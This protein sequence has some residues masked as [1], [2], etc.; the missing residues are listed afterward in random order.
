VLLLV[1]LVQA[2][3]GLQIILRDQRGACGARGR[4]LSRAAP[5]AGRRRIG[6]ALEREEHAAIGALNALAI[7]AATPQPSRVWATDGDRCRRLP[8]YEPNVALNRSVGEMR[9]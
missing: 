8:A 3:R 9:R 6:E 1:H 5:R 7:A 4:A 2:Q